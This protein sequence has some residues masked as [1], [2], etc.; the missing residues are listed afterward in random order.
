MEDLFE[1]SFTCQSCFTEEDCTIYEPEICYECGKEICSQC[2][3]DFGG[4]CE[5]CYDFLKKEN[6]DEKRKLWN[7]FWSSRL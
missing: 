4:F 1:K 5:D 6:E 2:V 3:I 7:D